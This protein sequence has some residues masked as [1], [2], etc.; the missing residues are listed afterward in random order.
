MGE[1]TISTKKYII[2]YGVILGILWVIYSV[3]RYITGYVTGGNWLLPIIEFSIHI[4]VIFYAIKKYKNANY[5]FLRLREAIMIGLGMALIAG[6]TAILWNVFL[7][8]VLEPEL[9]NEIRQ[10]RQED[11][12]KQNPDL[13]GEQIDQKIASTKEIGSSYL[14]S[15]IVLI[16][17]LLLGL[18][19][20]L[21]AGAIMQKNPDPFE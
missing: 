21:F 7:E 9:F 15:L 16:W 11:I 17:N 8:N 2:I 6:V 14:T 20:S 12:I 3:I 19:I 4:G 1:T 13:S 18:I 10:S 5:G